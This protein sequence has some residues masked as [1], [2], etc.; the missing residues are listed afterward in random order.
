MVIIVISAAIFHR[1]A[2]RRAVPHAVVG[3]GAGLVTTVVLL[4][5]PAWFAL[6]GPAHLSGLVWPNFHAAF[7]GNTV[8]DFVHPAPALST[9]F[10][11]SVMSKVVGGS[12]GP[13]PSF[14]VPWDWA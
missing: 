3:L 2:L 1:D 9:G 7:G 4:A 11:G 6:A 5:Y 14:A 8:G 12:Q 10:F 13:E